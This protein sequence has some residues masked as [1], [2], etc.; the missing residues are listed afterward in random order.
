MVL[1]LKFTKSP[2]IRNL[3][4]CQ[5]LQKAV[6]V[7]IA[8]KFTQKVTVNHMLPFP[9]ALYTSVTL[10]YNKQTLCKQWLP[11]YP[12]IY[13]STIMFAG[14]G[15]RHNVGGTKTK[16]KAQQLPQIQQHPQTPTTPKTP[17]NP[18][19]ATHGTHRPVN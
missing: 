7:Q 4:N 19:T 5:N 12:A 16:S 8:L 13:V 15:R 14:P 17:T 9:S 10:V 1:H 2:Q 11:L 3:Q 18:K 6:F